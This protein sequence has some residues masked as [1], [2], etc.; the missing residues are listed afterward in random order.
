MTAN[1]T[2]FTEASVDAHLATRGTAQQQADARALVALLGRITGA[3]A[4]M[5]GPSIV[6]FGTY[7]YTHDSGRTREAPLAAFAVRGRELVLYVDTQD[8]PQ[9][10]LLDQLGPHRTGASC[11]YL[12]RL[13]DLDLQV[14][15]ALVVGA[16]AARRCQD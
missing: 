1:K 6:G 8:E 5:W 13:A 16:V 7:R 9:R 12:K 11:L 14:L 15:E 3:P 4:R 2:A 10:G